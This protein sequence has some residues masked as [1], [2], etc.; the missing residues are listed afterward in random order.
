MNQNETLTKLEQFT[1]A[2]MQGLCASNATYLI[3]KEAV[4]VAKA[5]LKALEEEQ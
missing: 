1:L 5:T 4:A 3:S 2:A